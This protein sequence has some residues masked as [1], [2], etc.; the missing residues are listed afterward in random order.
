MKIKLG[1]KPY[2][3]D[4][5]ESGS[6]PLYPSM[7]ESPEHRWSFIRKVY[8]ILTFQLLL[9]IAVGAVVVNVREIPNFFLSKGVGLALYIVL[10]IAPFIV[11]VPLYY[12]HQRH[13]V[14][15]LLLGLFTVIIAFVVGLT[16]SLKHGKVVL[17]AMIL[18]AVV[19]VSLTLYTFWAARRGHDF[20]CLGP[21]LF[22]ALLV[23]TVFLLIQ[24]VFPMGKWQVMIIAGAASIIF[25]G[26]II[27]DTDNL[28]KRC[29]YDEYIWAAVSLYLDI[30]NLF[31]WIVAIITD[32][33]S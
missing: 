28:I 8:S 21:I 12:Y 9:T 18:T 3:K 33:D 27:Y 23:L 6:R 11:L 32:C 24:L 16:C 2:R 19:V 13:P 22:G 20:N 30:M 17:E 14:N 7:V 25:S 5:L 26:F 1:Q 29:S 15:Y 10:I 31:L 4:D